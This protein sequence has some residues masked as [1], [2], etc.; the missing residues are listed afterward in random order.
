MPLQLR[1]AYRRAS[2]AGTEEESRACRK[3]AWELRKKWVKD[4][5]RAE[6]NSRIKQN[7][8][9]GKAKKLHII[10][11]VK[12]EDQFLCG[13]EAHSIVV[14]HFASKFGVNHSQHIENMRD[15]AN[16]LSPVDVSVSHDE[17]VLALKEVR[18][19]RKIGKDGISLAVIKV[20]FKVVPDAMCSA[21]NDLV[22]DEVALRAEEVGGLAWGKEGSKPAPK[23]IRVIL[24]L[25]ASLNILDHVISHR[26]ASWCKSHFDLPESIY[27]GNTPKSQ[28]LDV[29]FASQ[30]V[31]EKGSDDHGAGVVAQCDIK[32]FF[33]HIS[34][35]LFYHRARQ[36][37]MHPALIAACFRMQ[38]FPSVW[39]KCLGCDGP[40]GVRST[41]SLTGSRVAGQLGN[42]IVYDSVDG[43]S[44][45]LSHRGFP[46]DSG[47]VS[48]ATWV[49]NLFSFS[50]TIANAVEIL[51]IVE[52]VLV[53]RWNLAIKQGSRAV[54]CSAGNMG[55][56]YSPEW[57]ILESVKILGH[58]VSGT[59]SIND[60]WKECSRMLWASFWR[61]NGN[62]QLSKL[63]MYLHFMLL[64]RAVL[65]TVM[66]KLS[67]WPYQKTVAVLLDGAMCRMA[68]RILPCERKPTEDIDQYCLHIFI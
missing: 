50:R 55:V 20:M 46:T 57:P 56:P 66:W 10:E 23:D 60:D 67:R 63:P 53:S 24:P 54:V 8:T 32:Q 36:R 37:G 58:I 59:G 35:V 19:A 4:R 12:V 5:R 22:N 51:L 62:R 27:I 44:A 40:V 9:L 25:S 16:R 48:L 29:A 39:I 31:L 34:P 68:A 47:P 64:Q 18:N 41:G 2:I 42:F 13:S 26:L 11:S 65:G 61:N 30:Q 17:C 28:C 7:K 45:E 52:R 43:V 6:C 3:H 33:D 1:E 14:N 21:L 38:L 15:V 49:D